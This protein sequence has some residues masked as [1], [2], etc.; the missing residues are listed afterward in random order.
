MDF[1]KESHF[2]TDKLLKTDFLYD[3]TSILR[4]AWLAIISSTPNLF[5][6]P[7]NTWVPMKLSGSTSLNMANN[8]SQLFLFYSEYF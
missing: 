7:T 6:K 8:F 2:L 4:L 5:R 3:E 1:A